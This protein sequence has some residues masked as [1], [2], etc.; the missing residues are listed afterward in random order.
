MSYIFVHIYIFQG[1]RG[2]KVVEQ[3]MYTSH[4]YQQFLRQVD[5]TIEITNCDLK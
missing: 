4:I 3:Q 1:R 2:C 5:E